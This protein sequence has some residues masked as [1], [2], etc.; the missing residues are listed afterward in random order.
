MDQVKKA[1]A[2][3]RQVRRG[4]ERTP[5]RLKEMAL[6]LVGRYGPTEVSQELGIYSSD[7]LRWRRLEKPNRRE[8]PSQ[9]RTAS[10]R[11]SRIRKRGIRAPA[12]KMSFV[13]LI[14][15]QASAQATT[16]PLTTIEWE[17][18]DGS[19]MRLSAS[20]SLKEIHWL[21]E[22]FLGTRPQDPRTEIGS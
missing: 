6:G 22:Q 18:S 19:R 13:E 17:R 5:S 16:S 2:L 14:P 21:S 15:T 10:R 3:W 4:Q 8:I 1:F 12:A 11:V 9:K 20:A 7:L